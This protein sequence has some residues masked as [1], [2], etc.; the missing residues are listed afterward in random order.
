MKRYNEYTV[1]ISTEPSY[2]GSEC[3]QIDANRIADN[4][5]ALVE[6]KFPGINI[7]KHT[8]GCVSKTT[9]PK[10]LVVD[11]INDWI[12]ENWTAAL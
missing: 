4:L 9:G 8:D 11:E 2:Y 12:S 1:R 6:E 10:Q 3:T 7:E 5:T